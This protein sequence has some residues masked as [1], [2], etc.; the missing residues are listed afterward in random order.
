MR[1]LLS[2]K[3]AQKL[4]SARLYLNQQLSFRL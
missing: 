1:L 4:F 2:P 3:S